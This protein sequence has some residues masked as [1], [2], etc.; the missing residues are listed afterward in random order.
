[1]SQPHPHESTRGNY[2]RELRAKQ[3]EGK[4]S[5]GINGDTG[6][7]V[8]MQEYGIW[9]PEAI[10]LQSI[11]TA[12]EVSFIYYFYLDSILILRQ[13]ACLLLRVDDICSA[14]K[15]QQVG[16]PGLGGGDD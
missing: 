14:K 10:K 5:W 16:A 13:A 15:A 9:E 2:R 12:I 6:T 3:A 8:D 4:S 7:I 11:K 1:M